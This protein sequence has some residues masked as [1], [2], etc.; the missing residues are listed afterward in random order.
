MSAG[1]TFALN[2]REVDALM[3]GVVLRSDVDFHVR[4]ATYHVISGSE[5]GET[6]RVEVNGHGMPLLRAAGA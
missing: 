1:I 5:G 6:G 2:L 3:G 4:R